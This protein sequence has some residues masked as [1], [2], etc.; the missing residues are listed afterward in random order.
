MGYRF[1]TYALQRGYV[2][3]GDKSARLH[4]YS[5]PAPLAYVNQPEVL[6]ARE[7][8][9]ADFTTSRE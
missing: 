2:D 4:L 8:P 7:L 3:G 9:R 5:P 1:Y 6:V